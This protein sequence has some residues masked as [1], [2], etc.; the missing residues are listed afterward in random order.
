MIRVFLG[1][2]P[3]ETVAF[4]V[5]SQS[6]HQHSSRPVS[7][8]P[9][10]LSQLE[11]IF[12]RPRDPKQSTDFSF[13]RFLVPY[14]CDYAGW[15]VFADSDILVRDDLARLWEL[16]DD[17]YAVQ[18]VKHQHVPTGRRKFLG[19]EQ[20]VYEKKNWS[21]LMLMNNA[22]CRALTLEYVHRAS[23]LDLHQFKWLADEALIGALPPR[24]NHL[25]DYD[26]AAP[27]GE[28][29]LLHYTEGGPWF[30]QY[31]DCGYA[32]EWRRALDE[33][34]RPSAGVT[35]RERGALLG[36]GEGREGVMADGLAQLSV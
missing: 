19:H 33:A 22:R 23:G 13:T 9:L 4:H 27:L 35:G 1:F 36:F 31:R 11:C 25:V 17:R 5:A 14:L 10:M 12:T 15:A 18:V 28:L 6:I 16:R 34:L 30:E 7:V 21:S 26:E 3:R 29:S 8:T 24:W 20:T 2:D 32:G